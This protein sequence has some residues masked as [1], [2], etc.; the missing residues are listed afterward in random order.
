[1]KDRPALVILHG[2][3]GSA[4]QMQPLCEMLDAHFHVLC[5]DLPGHGSDAQNSTPLSMQIFV[6]QVLKELEQ[7]GIAQA[8][9]FGYS[10][11]GYIALLLAARYPQKVLAV[12]TLA[13]KL[14]W[15]PSIAQGEAKRLKPEQIEARVPRFADEL[16]SRH[17]SGNWK[18]LVTKTAQLLA[19][20]GNTPDLQPA[21]WAKITCPVTI[22][23]GTEDPM[24]SQAECTE[25]A[26][27]LGQGR[28]LPIEGAKHPIESVDWKA[29]ASHV[30]LF[31]EE[32]VQAGD[33]R[34]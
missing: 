5:F 18:N 8:Y 13:T 21:D 19:D 23:L 9:F 3:L 4:S 29:L 26:E 16:K 22:A 6:D 32:S 10:M 31:F 20:L 15:D 30:Q 7:Q 24:V 17:A 11:G 28:F 2:A 27:A 14:V 25:V 12:F 34:P 33:W 1:M